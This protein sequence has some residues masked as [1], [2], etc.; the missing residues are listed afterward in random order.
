MT[1]C[2]TIET[3]ER[4]LDGSLPDPASA[5]VREHLDDCPQCL[6]ELD[7]LSEDDELR[8]WKVC[9]TEA[10]RQARQEAG[11]VSLLGRLRSS[12][13]VD[14]AAFETKDDRGPDLEL[15]PAIHS[16]D[17]GVLGPYRILRELGRGGMGIVL[18][19]AQHGISSSPDRRIRRRRGMVRPRAGPAPT[20][21]RRRAKPRRNAI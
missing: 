21:V 3:L 7:R 9:P 5:S 8:E 4:L 14:P 11:C 13:T 18:D 20:T 12:S 6:S 2:P 19:P 15:A 17:I 16:G 1:G 10:V